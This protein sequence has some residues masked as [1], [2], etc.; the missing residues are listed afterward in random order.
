MDSSLSKKKNGMKPW[1][2]FVTFENYG[3]LSSAFIF[4]CHGMMVYI[5]Q[6]QSTI[7]ELIYPHIISHII[8]GGIFRY[9]HSYLTCNWTVVIRDRVR[10]KTVIRPRPSWGKLRASCAIKFSCLLDMRVLQA[11]GYIRLHV[12]SF[13]LNALFIPDSGGTR[14]FSWLQAE[15]ML[16]IYFGWVVQ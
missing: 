4:P 3:N 9:F 11:M 7:L 10:C 16:N 12:G 13:P 14:N 2:I 8:Y 15:K 6:S 1:S 5:V